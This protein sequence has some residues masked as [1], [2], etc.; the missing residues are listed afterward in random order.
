MGSGSTV[1]SYADMFL[2]WTLHMN[3]NPYIF[4][5]S[6]HVLYLWYNKFFVVIYFSY[7]AEL[8]KQTKADIDAQ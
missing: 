1:L 3:L 4:T 2:S 6:V 8:A 7:H 5:I